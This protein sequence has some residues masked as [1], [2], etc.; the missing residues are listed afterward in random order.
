MDGDDLM[1][2]EERDILTGISERMTGASGDPE[3]FFEPV[4][5]T[6]PRPVATTCEHCRGRVG[7]RQLAVYPASGI[8]GADEDLDR[9]RVYLIANC[10]V[11]GSRIAMTRRQLR[12]AVTARADL[13]RLCAITLAVF[14]VIMS[15]A[16]FVLRA[17]MQERCLLQAR[18]AA[19]QNDAATQVQALTRARRYG[20]ADA[21][22]WLSR[23]YSTGN[24]VRQ[25][26][27]LA[28]RLLQ[29][30][31]DKGS[32]LA[33][34]QSAM[35]AYIRYLDNDQQVDLDTCVRQLRGCDAA[36]AQYMLSRL[37]RAGVG[38]TADAE[39]ADRILTRAAKGG[40]LPAVCDWLYLQWARG[41]GDEA[42]EVLDR[43]SS[44]NVPDLDA[45]RGWILLN[46]GSAQSGCQLLEAAAANG[47]ALAEL[48]LGDVYFY[49][50]MDGMTDLAMAREYYQAALD[51]G[52]ADALASLALCRYLLMDDGT[53]DPDQEMATIVA[54]ADLGYKEGS[55]RGAGVL[56]CLGEPASWDP[57]GDPDLYLEMAATNEWPFAEL[58][59]GWR[60]ADS[61][62][63]AGFEALLQEA[64]DHGAR[65]MANSEM[66]I[67]GYAEE[68]FG[69]N[70]LG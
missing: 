21:A 10:T 19:W 61:G 54:M 16:F 1:R 25:D 2:Q 14:A 18:E 62:D 69:P 52:N 34:Y 41:N 7:I 35:D 63:D 9:R 51:D 37:T 46:T 29:E 5:Y 45:A 50:M 60:R 26:D 33:V 22:Y 30:A 58:E 43:Y 32:S 49:G 6:L 42:L 23:C 40:C 11:C 39:S 24:G 53:E 38:V 57:R 15:A 65:W 3:A 66:Y 56:G 27:A 70:Q 8:M 4:R 55:L 64:Y 68:Y 13:I 59:A 47:S 44:L 36:Q 31:E 48:Y 28:Q 12:K 67:L 20:S 17:R